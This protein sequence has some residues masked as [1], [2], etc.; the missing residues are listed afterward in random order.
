VAASLLVASSGVAT[1]PPVGASV[2]GDLASAQRRADAA[3]AAFARSERDLAKAEDQVGVV[4][5]RLADARGRV[6]VLER[7]VQG[8]LVSQY[9]QGGLQVPFL[10]SSDINASVRGNELA[11]FVTAGALDSLSDIRGARDDL[12]AA[13]RDLDQRLGQRKAAVASLRKAQSRAAAE[14]DRL[15]LL[16]RQLAARASD[17]QARSQALAARAAAS[18]SAPEVDTGDGVLP[19]DV[20]TPAR[21][22]GSGWICPVAGPRAFSD[23]YGDARGGGRRHQ[24]NDIL[25]PRGTPVVA[26]VAGDVSRH[27]NRLGGLSYYLHG[28]DGNTY[29]GAHLSAY[30]ADGHVSAGT[31]IGYVGNS[32]DASGGP[33][34]LHFEYHPGGGGAVNPYTLLRAAC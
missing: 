33:T 4:R 18:R 16:Q 19:P 21:A 23:D 24:G 12:A 28:D 9:V 31:V 6:G 2:E 14:V 17:Q 26:N 11:R 29:Y 20:N 7:A 34:H 27:P 13:Q 10:V 5:S 30:G 22:R 8:A 1:A 3:A 25:A 32:G 15:G